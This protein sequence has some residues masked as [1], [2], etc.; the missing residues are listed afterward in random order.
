MRLV[1]QVPTG[2]PAGALLA[3]LSGRGLEA[4]VREGELWLLDEDRLPEATE[5]LERFTRQ[6]D[7]ADWRVAVANAR[8]RRDEEL[9]TAREQLDE[10]ARLAWRRERRLR[11]AFQDAPS[12]RPL[13]LALLA[14][15]ALSAWSG[16]HEMSVLLPVFATLYWLHELGTHVEAL[17]GSRRF[18]LLL[19]SVAA[20]SQ[21]ALA[22]TGLGLAGLSGSGFG[23]LG[24]TVA[25]SRFDAG[26][27]LRVPPGL[28]SLMA[29]WLIACAAGA[30]QASVF[31]AQFTGLVAGLVAGTLPPALARQRRRRRHELLDE[32][33][34]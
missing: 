2:R 25:R 29:A 27:G 6:P 32:F 22:I 20:T 18:A 11:S 26:A 5:E 1:G 4:V 34:P 30:A 9:R 19:L 33:G 23:L 17:C 12:S 28:L 3:V 15:G 7:C 8:V 13:T 21:L 16:P 31:L 14:A 24:F 10:R